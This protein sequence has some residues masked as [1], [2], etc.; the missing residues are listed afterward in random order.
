MTKEY[1]HSD[2]VHYALNYAINLMH[3]GSVGFIN[4]KKTYTVD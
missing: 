1:S 3:G 2:V 4:Y